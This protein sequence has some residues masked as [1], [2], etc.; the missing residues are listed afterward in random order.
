MRFKTPVLVALAAFATVAVDWASLREAVNALPAQRAQSE[1]VPILLSTAF[2]ATSSPVEGQG[3][4]AREEG[5]PAF[6]P[7]APAQAS[8]EDDADNDAP[9]M[10]SVARETWIFAEPRWDARRLGYL[11]AGAIVERGLQPV[12]HQSCKQGWYRVEPRGFVCH[13]S[14]HASLDADHPVAKLSTREPDM[15]RLPYTYAMSRYPTPAM[16]A[17]LPTTEQQQRAEP[18]LGYRLRKHARTVKSGDYVP[19]PPADAIPEIIRDGGLLPALG[20]VRRATSTVTLG[21]ARAR[22]GFGLIATY[23][24]EGRRFG[25]T[26][27]LALLPLDG[28]RMVEPTAYRGV[29]LSDEFRLPIG[30]VRSKKARRY[31][32]H[33]ETGALSLDGKFAWRET[34]QLTGK[35]KRSRGSLYRETRG[36]SWVRGDLLARIEPFEQAPRWARQGKKWIDV[37]ILR[38]TLVAY[39]GLKPVYATIVST[40]AD[41]LADHEES[42]ATIRGTFLIHTKHVSTTMDGDERGAEFDLRDVPFV[43]YF[44]EGYALHAAYWHDDFGTPRSHGCVNLAPEDAAWLFGWTDPQVPTGWHAALELKHGTIVHIHP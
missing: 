44:T 29:Q 11:R 28:M 41:G 12:T 16:Y 5:A 38:Q 14:T 15:S 1:A 7:V 43:Q 37:S 35:L 17:R 6:P 30:V 36:G 40:G 23:D 3:A 27:E 39:Q 26:T 22:S 19:P 21:R 25:L 8:V 13:K 24:Y 9:V 31:R 20:G 42:H 18:D 4:T 10:V 33:E 32:I 34:L 2:A